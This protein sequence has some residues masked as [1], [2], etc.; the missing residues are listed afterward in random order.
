VLVDDRRVPEP[1]T[2]GGPGAL[3]VERARRVHGV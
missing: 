1:P 2:T 3:V